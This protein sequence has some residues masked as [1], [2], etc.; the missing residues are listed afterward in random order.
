M[1]V[2]LRKCSFVLQAESCK[3]GRCRPMSQLLSKLKLVRFVLLPSSDHQAFVNRRLMQL[4]PRMAPLYMDCP[5]AMCCS[6]NLREPKVIIPTLVA[7]TVACPEETSQ[8]NQAGFPTQNPN[9]EGPLLASAVTCNPVFA[10]SYRL[11]LNLQSFEL[12][13]KHIM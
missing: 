6:E 9:L 5:Q 8:K 7:P 13:H 4:Q 2:T 3:L 1:I 11:R 12:D 10:Q